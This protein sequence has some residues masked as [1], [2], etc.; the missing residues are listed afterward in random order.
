VSDRLGIGIVVNNLPGDEAG[1]AQLQ[2]LRIAREL[3]REHRVTL[4]SR[5]GPQSLDRIDRID[6]ID[7]T[8]GIDGRSLDIVLRRK[9]SI[10][11]IRLLEDVRIATRQIRS[12]REDLDA[13]VCYQTVTPGLI[14]ACAHGFGVP[15]LLYIRGRLE[16]LSGRLSPRRSLASFALGRAARVLVQSES[17]R[18]EVLERFGDRRFGDRRR[19]VER[20]RE[21]IRVIP[22]GVDRRPLRVGAGRYLVYVGRLVALKGVADLVDAMREFPDVPL[23]LVGD[24]PD[25]DRLRGLASGVQASFLGHVSHEEVLRHIEGAACLVLPSRTEAF[26]NVILEAMSLGVP[27]I[28]TRVGGNPDLVRDGENGLLVPP[29][30]PPA[31]ARAIREMLGSETRRLELGRCAHAMAQHYDW[32]RATRLLLHEIREA[33]GEARDS[34]ARPAI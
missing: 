5:G 16:Y 9:A 7:G 31:L 13:L 20:L 14:G 29:G 26:S 3:S 12:R 15:Y 19:L 23:I 2:A 25:R 10:P 24:G 8:D 34:R 11:G 6:R 21:R 1:G 4:F 17:I 30:D 18:D 22:N 27:V 28:A 33:V 32:D